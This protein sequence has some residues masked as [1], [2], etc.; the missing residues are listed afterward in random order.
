MRVLVTGGT[1]FVGSN[2]A[3]ALVDRGHEVRILRRERSDLRALGTLAVEHAIGDVRDFE[4]VQRAVEGCA[5]VYHTAAMVSYWRKQRQEMFTIN[6]E[7]TRNVVRACLRQ[8]VQKLI[9]TSSIAAIGHTTDGSLADE[10]TPFNWD[11]YDIGYRISKYRSEQVVLEGVQNGL[12]AVMVNPSVILGPGDIHFHGGQIIRDVRK[13]RLFYYVDGGT[14]LVSVDDVV[15]G[16]LAAAE[17]GRI[18]ERYILS[19]ENLTHRAMLT[20]VAEVVGGIRPVVRLPRPFVRLL[21]TT[22]EVI[23]N[24]TNRKPWITKELAAGIHLTSW[25]SGEK[26]KRELGYVFTPFRETV[27][28]TYRWYVENG[29]LT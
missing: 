1:G 23:G 27:V 9:H 22:S 16:H 8:N 15:R 11:R 7:G 20:I 14:N 28:Q 10:T 18:G 24:L 3:R 6:I 25:F 2:L 26:A 29:L 4:S 13:R 19:G 21:A 17:R 12:F 5:I